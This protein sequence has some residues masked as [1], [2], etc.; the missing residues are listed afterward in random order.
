MILDSIGDK[1]IKIINSIFAPAGEFFIFMYKCFKTLF[2]QK[3][4]LRNIL[5]QFWEIGFNSLLLVATTAV[6]TGGVLALQTYSGAMEFGIEKTVPTI[7]V[8]GLTRELGPILV[9][10]MVAGKTS[11]S[12]AAELSTMR[13]TEQI[14]ALYILSTSPF[15][16]LIMPRIIATTIAVPIL[17]LIADVIGIFGGTVASVF[18]LNMNLYNYVI[19]SCNQL[20]WT[21]TMSGIIKAFAF[22]FIISVAGCYSGYRAKGGAVGVGKATIEAIVSASIF[23][24]LANYF[25]TQ[26][27]FI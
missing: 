7:V 6:F 3:W 21:D 15:A 12:I 19:N 11:T 17:V 24:L 14:D 26:F 20:N 9:G 22:G 18:A 4:Y 16:F 5:Q 13:V 1:T 23:I 25:M 2:T 8:L 27:F 10:L